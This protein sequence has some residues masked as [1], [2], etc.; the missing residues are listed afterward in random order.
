[1]H[2]QMEQLHK[3]NLK[4]KKEKVV[5]FPK[6]SCIIQVY[7]CGFFPKKSINASGF[8]VLQLSAELAVTVLNH[9]FIFLV[10][11]MMKTMATSVLFHE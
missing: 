3:F 7:V 10:Y 9:L 4:K 5:P 1:M 8:N 6:A 2:F 11:N